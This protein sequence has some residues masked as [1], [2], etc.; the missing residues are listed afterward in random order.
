MEN[1]T[2][3]QE[4][5]LKERDEINN[6]L[7]ALIVKFKE[8]RKIRESIVPFNQPACLLLREGRKGEILESKKKNGLATGKFKFIHS[9][10]EDKEVDLKGA[11]LYTIPYPDGE[12]KIFVHHENWAFPM[13]IEDPYFEFLRVKDAVDHAF[14]A[15]MKWKT[16]EAKAR[17][18]MLMWIAVIVAILAGAFI[19]YLVLK[20]NPTYLVQAA[21]AANDSIQ[22]IPNG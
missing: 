1:I 11:P 12:L 20:P 3:R 6:K 7:S 13:V 22:I 9:N 2:E 17:G 8:G 16:E 18:N 5:E 19:L 14:S 15:E 4:R 10:G 21:Q